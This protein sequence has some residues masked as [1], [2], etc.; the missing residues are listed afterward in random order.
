MAA[1]AIILAGATALQAIGGIAQANANAAALNQQ[2]NV[3]DYNA[4]VSRE[5]AGQALSVSTAQ[6]LALRRQQRQ[7]AGTMRAAAAQSGVGFG[8][9]TRDVLERTDTLNELDA[10]NLAYEGALRARGYSTQ[11]DLEQFNARAYRSQAST[12]K[13][14]GF[15]GAFG[16]AAAGAYRFSSMRTTV[17]S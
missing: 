13:K 10:L 7:Q 4:A 11:S 6:Q 15:L 12:T 1:P 8:G 3:A 2:A 16:S 9:S 5:Q 14:L 17:G